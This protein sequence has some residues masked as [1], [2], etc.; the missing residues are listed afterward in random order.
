[1]DKTRRIVLY[2]EHLYTDLGHRDDKIRK[3]V[4][5]LKFYF[6]L[7]CIDC[8]YLDSLVVNRAK[9]AGKRSTTEARELA[10]ARI[11]TLKI[12]LSFDVIW[13]LRATHWEN[14]T[15]TIAGNL[16]NRAIWLCAAVGFDSGPRISNLT[17]KDEKSAEDHCVRGSDVVFAVRD[18][19]SGKTEWL[20]AGSLVREFWTR[21]ETKIT[22]VLEVSLT[23]NTTKT[24]GSGQS[25]VADRKPIQRRSPAECTVL[26]DLWWWVVYSGVKQTDELF[27]RYATVVKGAGNRKHECL[28]SRKVL[29]RGAFTVAIKDAGE[30]FKIP[31]LNVSTK[32]MRGGFATHCRAEGATDAQRNERG[33]WAKDSTVPERH[34]VREMHRP[35]ALA[36]VCN[37]VS[38]KYTVEDMHAMLGAKSSHNES[39]N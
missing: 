36:M 12:P 7:Q 30:V 38:A 2:L 14:R 13:S 37:G 21:P 28:N 20:Q 25:Q 1:M 9:K 11:A 5:A 34:Y 35:G 10:T 4:T 23:F 3:A 29:T 27:T 15:W 33:D 6:S 18:P 17:L 32:G 31:R 8:D 22:D 16:D 39:N 26:E 24:I 19:L